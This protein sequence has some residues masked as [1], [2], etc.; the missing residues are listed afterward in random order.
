MGKDKNIEK[1]VK[2]RKRGNT[3]LIYTI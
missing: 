1:C 3:F 2:Y